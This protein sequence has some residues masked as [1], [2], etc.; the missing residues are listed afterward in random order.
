MIKKLHDILADRQSIEE[1]RRKA[2]K[3][4]TKSNYWTQEELDW[5]RKKAEIWEKELNKIFE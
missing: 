5:A 1:L 4:K 3:S 2:L